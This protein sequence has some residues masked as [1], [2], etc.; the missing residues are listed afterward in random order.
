MGPGPPW[1][2]RSPRSCSVRSLL[3]AKRRAF[4]PSFRAPKAWPSMAIPACGWRDPALVIGWALAHHELH[5]RPGFAWSLGRLKRRARAFGQPFGLPDLLLFACPKRSRQEKG[6]PSSAPFAH[7]CAQGSRESVGVR[8]QAIP[9]LSRTSAASL[10]PTLRADPR[11]PAA[12]QGP[13]EERGLLPARARAKA[14]SSGWAGLDPPKPCGV[15]SVR[16]SRRQAPPRH[17]AADLRPN[18]S[19]SPRETWINGDLPSP[20]LA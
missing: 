16:S 7:P 4:G 20:A 15:L 11:T 10:R 1:A 2:P 8:G 3:E 18:G 13:R 9:G 19:G 6:H 5:A 17:T 12:P 14:R